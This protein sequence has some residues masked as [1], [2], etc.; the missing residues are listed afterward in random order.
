MSSGWSRAFVFVGLVALIANAP[1]FGN[2]ASEACSSTKTPS[3]SCHHHKSSPE[4]SARCS[5]QHSEFAAPE[6]DIVKV[7]IAAAVAILPALTSDSAAGT[8]ESHFLSQFDT[9]SPPGNHSGSTISVLR[10]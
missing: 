2:C 1:C 3:N 4:D 10:I 6:T 7:N 8:V 9:G 5:H